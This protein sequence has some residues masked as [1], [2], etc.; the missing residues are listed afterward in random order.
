[1]SLDDRNIH[2]STTPTRVSSS[3]TIPYRPQDPDH[4]IY[5]DGSESSF[6]VGSPDQFP[7]NTPPRGSIPI[8]NIGVDNTSPRF[9]PLLGNRSTSSPLLVRRRATSNNQRITSG[10]MG[11]GHMGTPQPE[12]QWTLFGQLMENEGQL[13]SPSSHHTSWRAA[14]SSRPRVDQLSE[15]IGSG[16]DFGTPR[17]SNPDPFLDVHS[18]T[19]EDENFSDDTTRFPSRAPSLHEA[20]PNRQ[21]DD[22]DSDDADNSDTSEEAHPTSQSSTPPP[23]YSPRRIPTVPLL[24]RNMLKCSI[25][26]FIASLFTFSPIL[27]KLISDLTSYG[28]GPHKPFPS[29]HMVASMYVFRP[30]Y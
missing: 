14:S 26:Y 5:S 18:V 17:R 20:F 10:I 16:S 19:E 11:L 15:S 12:H 22:E 2:G 3:M 27:S 9:R 6:L 30:P 4:P 29:G 21:S 24:Y 25:A 7:Y 1:M 13:P 8:P 28:P 23:W